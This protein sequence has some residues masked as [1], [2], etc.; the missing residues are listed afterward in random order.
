MKT[1]MMA[2]MICAAF[3]AGVGAA[4]AASCTK[5]IDQF[6]AAMRASGNGPDLGPTAPETT[7]AKLGHQPT[8]ASVA[9]AESRAQSRFT[10]LL[11]RAQA[12]DAQ[13]KHASCMRALTAAK[14]MY[15]PQ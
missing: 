4:H 10:A 9:R 2:L 5:Q 3:G 15:D 14:L 6:E 7:A 13:G 12:L 8:P 11:A 1:L